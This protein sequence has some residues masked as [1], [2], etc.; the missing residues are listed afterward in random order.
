MEDLSIVIQAGGKSSRMGKDKGLMDFGGITLVEYIYQQIREIGDEILLISNQ[1]YEYHFLSIPVYTDVQPGIGAL[2]GLQTALT[3][4]R[5]PWVLVLAC[6]MP[7]INIKLIE[8]MLSFRDSNDVVVPLLGKKQFAEPFRALYSRAIL[9]EIETAIQS[10]KR[11]A[12][13]FYKDLRVK[14][15]LQDEIDQLDPEGLTFYNLN[16]PEDYQN[17]LGMIS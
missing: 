3:Y 12:I 13:A 9:P 17:A 11:R 5:A 10:G 7:F 4:S 8:F 14:G 1:P 2:G 15:L 16:T 6:D